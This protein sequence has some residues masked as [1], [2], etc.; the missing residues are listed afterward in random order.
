VELRL[1]PALRFLRAAFFCHLLW[2]VGCG[3][4]FCFRVVSAAAGDFDVSCFCFCCCCCCGGD[5]DCCSSFAVA[6]FT[7][8]AVGGSTVTT[9]AVSAGAGCCCCCCCCEARLAFFARSSSS[10]LRASRSWFLSFSI[11]SSSSPS[12]TACERPMLPRSAKALFSAAVRRD[13]STSS[14]IFRIM[15]CMTAIRSSRFLR[16]S[17]ATNGGTKRHFL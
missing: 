2:P 9:G 6:S 4:P 5:G 16:S 10:C 13:C 3:L 1:R 12:R 7:G 15:L 14:C 17:V 11:C 8:P